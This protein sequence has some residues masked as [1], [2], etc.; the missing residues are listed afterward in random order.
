LELVKTFVAAGFPVMMPTWHIDSPRNQMGHYRLVHGYDD[1][2]AEFAVRDS[3]EPIGYRMGYREFDLLWRVFN[4]RMVV[5]YPRERADGLFSIVSSTGSGDENLESSLEK[6]ALETEPPTELPEGMSAGNYMAYSEFNRAM[7][8]TALDR[9]DQAAE[10]LFSAFEYGLPWRMLWYQPEVLESVYEVG[11][12]QWIIDRTGRALAP[13][14]YLEE[15]WYWKGRA[16]AMLGHRDKAL[17]AY[18]RALDIQPGWSAP[19]QALEVA[20]VEIN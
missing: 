15:L 20:V 14:P 9:Y 4:R 2:A 12:Y 1:E 19:I 10:A 11:E 5:V 8:L 3:L 16:E 7:V 17:E 6:A 13:Y 18:R